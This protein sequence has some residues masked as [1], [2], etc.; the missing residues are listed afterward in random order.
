MNTFRNLASGAIAIAALTACGGGGGA[1]PGGGAASIEL[2]VTLGQAGPGDPEGYFPLAQG[3][4]W[5]FR[6]TAVENGVPTPF[7]TSVQVSGTSVVGGVTALVVRESDP[8]VGGCCSFSEQAVVKDPNG[9]AVLAESTDPLTK[10][11][12]P[13]WELRFP[14]NSGLEF[15]Q[16]DRL[17]IDI[18]QDLDGDGINEWADVHSI[19][20]VIGFETV[21]APAG[22]FSEAAHIRRQV[23]LKFHMSRDG[24]VVEASETG[25]TWFARGVGWVRRTS[26]VSVLGQSSTSDESLDAY[27]VDGVAGGG[28]QEAADPVQNSSLGPE[29]TSF[30]LWRNVAAGRH[31]VALTGRTGDARLRILAGSCTAGSGSTLPPED[32]SFDASTGPVVVQVTGTAG[33]HYQLW[34][35]PTPRVLTPA[36]EV[37]AITAG[38][39]TV[40]Q[41]ATRSDSRYEVTGLTPGNYTISIAGLSADADLKVYFDGTYSMEQDC[42]LRAAGDVLPQPEDC[43]TASPGSLYFSVRSGEVNRDGAS[44]LMLVHA[45]P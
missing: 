14:L 33:T 38:V 28:I 45:A 9:L 35:A 25:N 42:T 5:H 40:G 6:G 41:V 7:E 23:A 8:T 13:Y 11:L 29:G 4:F 27:F 12:A 3:N 34:H 31:T 10:S 39:P 44:Y 22:T 24:Q 37:R 30:W 2:P 18:G 15:V 1:D 36:N 32:C 21:S 17:A 26:A 19:A 20:T 43:T 16:I